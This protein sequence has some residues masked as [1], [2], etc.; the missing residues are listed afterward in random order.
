M[1]LIYNKKEKKW[2]SVIRVTLNKQTGEH[3][4]SKSNDGEGIYLDGKLVEKLE[5]IQKIIKKN[6]DAVFIIDGTERIGKSTLALT[7]AYFLTNT[8]LSIKNVCIGSKDAVEKLKNLP[9]K[10]LLL[11]DEGSLMFSSMDVMKAE[12]RRLNKILNVIGQKNMMLIIVAP[13]FF[14]LSKYISVHRSRFLLHCY[15]DN[16]LNRG[17]FAYFSTNRKR[18][19]YEIGK[20]NFGSYRKPESSFIGR[21]TDFKVPFYDE[22][23]ETKKKT[24][25]GVLQEEKVGVSQADKREQR[26]EIIKNNEELPEKKR[27]TT[28]QLSE[29]L[30]VSVRTIQQDIREFR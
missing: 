25:M 27:L 18:M 3:E 29:L 13:S 22:Y 30:K 23:L 6:W 24:L 26:R 8:K 2:Q 21:Y 11:I 28:K 19:L 1:K 7:C 17:R 15:T 4:I 9:D 5:Y 10:S 20:K 16:K 14:D 12:N